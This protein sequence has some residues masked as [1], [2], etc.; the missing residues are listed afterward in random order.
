MH[1]QLKHEQQA[2][3]TSGDTCRTMIWNVR[4]RITLR[5]SSQTRLFGT[6]PRVCVL[7]LSGARS[8]LQCMQHVEK[9]SADRQTT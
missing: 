5:T 7:V 4:I 1:L 2:E 3:G 8:S 6:C 9:H